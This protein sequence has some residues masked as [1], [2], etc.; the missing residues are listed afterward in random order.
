MAIDFPS[1]P[2]IDD[3][4]TAA[5]T[6]WKWDGTVWIKLGFVGPTGPQGAQGPQGDGVNTL[7]VV[8]NMQVFN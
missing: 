5:G 3:E 8:Y 4:F 7:Q 1:S 6:T 2:D